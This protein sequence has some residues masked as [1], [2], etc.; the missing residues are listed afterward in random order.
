M[1]RRQTKFEQVTGNA[2][3]SLVQ[4]LLPFANCSA[5]VLLLQVPHQP[6][7][8]SAS[9]AAIPFFSWSSQSIPSGLDEPDFQLADVIA[10]SYDSY[11]REFAEGARDWG[12]PFFLRFDWEMNGN[13]FPWSEGVNGNQSGEYVAAWRHVHDIFTAVGA[14]NVTWVWCP[15]VDPDNEL[16]DLASSTRATNT[17]TGPAS[18]ATTGAP[19]ARRPAGAASTPLQRHLHRITTDRAHQAD[20]DRRD[21]LRG[22]RRLEGATGSATR[23][24]PSCPRTSPRSRHSSGSTGASTRKAN[25]GGR[26]RSNPP[27][28]PRPPSRPRSAPPTTHPAAATATSPCVSKSRRSRRAY[29]S[30]T[31]VAPPAG[32]CTALGAG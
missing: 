9:T 26:G 31:A 8:R 7:K 5:L 18:T 30:R 20:D 32:C 3:V 24:P 23:S 6:M 17:S 15:N 22:K 16:H 2:D 19:P 27:P 14:T 4:L 1:R 29:R 25:T 11:I 21:L 10:G 12:H 28:A 13:W